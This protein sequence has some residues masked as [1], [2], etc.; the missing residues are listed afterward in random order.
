[1]KIYIV[2]EGEFDTDSPREYMAEPT[3]LLVTTDEEKAKNLLKE[4]F[5][6]Y[7]EYREDYCVEYH[8]D[9]FT[10]T[11]NSY[12]Y[13]KVGIITKELEKLE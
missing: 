9:N 1:V 5:K 6:W 3:I 13:G 12:T 7:K 4:K 8:G 2:Y 11:D 10:F